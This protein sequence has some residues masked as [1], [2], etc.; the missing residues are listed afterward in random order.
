MITDRKW[1][2]SSQAEKLCLFKQ[3]AYGLKFMHE[4]D[5]VHRDLKPENIL[6]SQN[7][8]VKITDFGVSDYG[9]LVPGDWSSGINMSNL[10]VGSP[11]YNSPEVQ[12]LNGIQISKRTPY[13]PF[14]MDY[15]GLGMILFV[16]F[17]TTIP[18]EECS[19]TDPNYREYEAAYEKFCLTSAPRFRS[20][21]YTRGP[22]LESR[23][24]RVFNDKGI[25][26][27]AWRLCD[28]NVKTRY[29]MFELFNDPAFQKIEMCIEENDF[30]CNFFHHSDSK[31]K[32]KYEYGDTVS[33]TDQSI[34]SGGK[35][36]RAGT[37]SSA[38]G[39]ASP[40]SPS[41]GAFGD[42][43]GT[44]ND[45][46][47]VPRKSM[48]DVLSSPTP[49][50]KSTSTSTP[51]NG[52]AANNAAITTNGNK[53]PNGS[54]TAAQ[55]AESTTSSTS[56]NTT[57]TPTT[58][59][60]ASSTTTNGSATNGSTTPADGNSI[61][62]VPASI[63]ISVSSSNQA[64]LPSLDEQSELKSPTQPSTS[65]TQ[66]Q[67]QA[68]PSTQSL[69]S[70][71]TTPPTTTTTAA[72]TTTATTLQVPHKQPSSQTLTSLYH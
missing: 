52:T 29:T 4:C 70:S 35:R 51:A 21:D 54:T 18:F 44:T 57:S 42:G 37:V 63:S 55:V 60:P 72:P 50:K 6:L 15:W 68:D 46:P 47:V 69:A 27:I 24:G 3:I 12:A 17:L 64:P 22:G 65:Q 32:G 31:F 49:Q 20:N 16:M 45:A 36:S 28:P 58:T 30:E 13:N 23:F 19:K 62:A 8:V 1:N 25:A 9:H 56:T 7:G 59:T 71:T 5:I 2:A 43:N 67:P 53:E 34:G 38:K 26:R 40:V 48:L 41:S 11:P 61:T 66:P 39:L 33:H 10:L 14:K